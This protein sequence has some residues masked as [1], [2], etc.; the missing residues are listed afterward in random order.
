MAYIGMACIVIAY[1][2]GL[3]SY[4]LVMSYMIMACIVMAC[5]V[6][7]YCFTVRGIC[8][9]IN[10]RSAGRVIKGVGTRSRAS[11][12]PQ[13]RTTAC[14]CA[15]PAACGPQ[16][17]TVRAC[18]CMRARTCLHVQIYVHSHALACISAHM[19]RMHVQVKLG[20]GGRGGR[21]R[22]ANSALQRGRSK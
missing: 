16:P 15:W 12:R 14:M 9:S 7:A 2:L 13:A 6:V 5:I 21:G 19:S 8:G 22:F 18:A 4:G 3:N 10:R 17:V 20:G 11:H 1:S